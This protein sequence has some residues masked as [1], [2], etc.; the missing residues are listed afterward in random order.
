[1]SRWQLLGSCLAIIV[2]LSGIVLVVRSRPTTIGPLRTGKEVNL[3]ALSEIEEMRADVFDSPN[4]F[5]DTYNVAIPKDNQEE[6][7]SYFRPGK[8]AWFPSQWREFGRITIKSK[9][10][11]TMTLVFYQAGNNHLCYSHAGTLYMHET[12]RWWEANKLEG[13]IRE[14]R[15]HELQKKKE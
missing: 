8:E 9:V 3:P 7:L 5:K 10:G 2:M 12:D 15:L 4:Q 6:I 1:M 13:L 11:A 14:I